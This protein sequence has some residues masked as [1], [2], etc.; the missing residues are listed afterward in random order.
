MS[1]ISAAAATDQAVTSATP[2][3]FSEMDTE[4][5]IRVIFTEL[6]NQDP[7]QPNDT[8]ALL[9][10]LNSIRSIESDLQLTRQLEALVSE[11]QLASA[12]NMI[13]KFVTGRTE[14]FADAAGFVLSALKQGDE[15]RLELSSGQLVPLENVE[16]VIA[17]ELIGGGDP[18]PDEQSSEESTE[19]SDG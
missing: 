17:P 1:A 2:N 14:Q 15:I 19:E 11:N 3:R 18:P 4:D 7:L 16:A 8:S 9:D 13:G 6:T 10:Q 12:S 5:F